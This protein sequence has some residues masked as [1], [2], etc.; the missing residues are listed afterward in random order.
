MQDQQ[1]RSATPVF[2]VEPAPVITEARPRGY[3]GKHR[4]TST[5]R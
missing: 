4:G 3:K 5:T 2:V 1:P